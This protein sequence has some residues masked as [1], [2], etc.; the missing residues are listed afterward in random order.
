MSDTKRT[1]SE[2]EH[3]AILTDT[4]RRERAAAVEELETEKAELQTRIDVLEAEK[5]EALQAKEAA[6]TELEEFKAGIETEKEVAARK[7]ERADA[8]KDVTTL[9]D[10]YFTDERVTRWAEMSEEA[11]ETFLDDM[12][13]QTLARLS[14]EQRTEIAQ[15][16]DGEAKRKKI[17]AYLEA[18]RESK[19]REGAST[20][21]IP[22]TAA[23]SGGK[24]PAGD[25]TGR[26]TLSTFLG[27]TAGA[28]ASN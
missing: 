12:A 22:E 6:E 27:A 3:E 14:E 4:V 23:F 7:T 21:V 5:A 2:A 25:G 28:P 19:E 26:S 9:P 16:E 13:E 10:T 20:S 8:V 11:F 15:I 17:A 1:F 18:A 24:T